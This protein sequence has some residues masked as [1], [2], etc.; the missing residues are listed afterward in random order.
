MSE[1]EVGGAGWA[2]ESCTLPA[3]QRPVRSADFD[4]FFAGAVL[5]VER[6]SPTGLRLELEPGPRAAARAAE[7]AAAEV[8]C[9][10]FFTFTLTVT[11][12][13]LTLDITAPAS[14]AAVLD[15]LAARAE[16]ARARR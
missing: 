13:G 12:P 14:H 4:E 15:A 7:L 5:G 2:P 6:T 11:G 10:S 1:P 3:A 9:C 8:G 16:T